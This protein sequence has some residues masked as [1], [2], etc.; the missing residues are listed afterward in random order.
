MFFR[1]LYDEKLAQASY[2]LAC[3]QTGEALVVDPQRD[4]E[5][6]LALARSKNFRIVGIAETH[7]H[8]DFLSGARELAERTGARLYLSN[9]GDADWKYRW[10]DKKS[11]GG[12][13]D[14]RLL[15][16][17]DSFRI[18][19]IRIT[20]KHTP[21]HTPEHLS[22]LV[23]DEG[24]GATE[25]MGVLSGDFVFVGDVGRPD[26]LESAAG[27]AG[28]K[29]ASARL[30]YRSLQEF[31]NL[32]DFLQLWPGHGSGSACGKALGAVPQSTVGYE[33]RFNPAVSLASSQERFV[34]EILYGQ[35]EPPLYFARMKRLNRDGPP[36]LGALPQ[37]K[38][39]TLHEVVEVLDDQAVLLD[40][41]TWQAFSAGHL[42]GALFAPLNTAFPTVAGSY[43]LP[44]QRV[45]LLVEPERLQEAVVALIRI[46]L[47][48]VVGYITPADLKAARPSP[49]L[50]QQ[51]PVVPIQ[52]VE[53]AALA[54]EAILLDVRY[55]NEYDAGHLPGAQHIAHTRLLERLEELPRNRPVYVYCKTGS[56]SAYA[57]GLLKR[58]G[59][60]VTLLAG[61]FDAWTAAGKP[62]EQAQPVTH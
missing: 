38:H 5:R 40:T 29:E 14:C 18:G 32:P 54:E 9:E 15:H 30:L 34:A 24:G 52:Q 37:P 39:V 1:M 13:N 60:S 48:Q 23:T 21:G 42:R 26:L 31:V 27:I 41:R 36:L 28:A 12:R 10:L 49:E 11:T 62:V 56:R 35:P 57:S 25:P 17:G 47:D 6:Y 43:V 19:G 8:A 58:F 20:A 3:Q 55:R 44:E 33:K 45:Y 51:V 7:I 59:Y 53:P 50:L 22:F 4:V 16:D 46:G 2:L 61:G